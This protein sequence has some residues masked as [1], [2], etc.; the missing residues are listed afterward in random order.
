MS[1]GLSVTVT[2]LL[3]KRADFLGGIHVLSLFCIPVNESA[4]VQRL[5]EL[6]VISLY[7]NPEKLAF[8]QR[9]DVLAFDGLGQISSELKSCIDMIMR[10][11]RK[12]DQYMGGVLVLATID[13][14]QLRPIKG[15]PFLLSPFVLTCYRFS[16]L[17][18]SVRA[19]DDPFLQRIQNITRMLTHE[20]TPEIINKLSELLERHCTF[21][22]S[23]SDP[24][25]PPTMLRCFG[26]KAAIWQEGIRFM[27]EIG[28]SGRTVLYR[29]ADVHIGNLQLHL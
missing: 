6:A 11:I 24:S 27:N 25:I 16:V 22:E 17:K 1:R 26:K 9:L 28:S 21:V 14:I 8:L 15:R 13:P 10:R 20:Y 29:E 2:C 12:S 5:A 23:W 19:A 4:S 7:K 3:A 18:H